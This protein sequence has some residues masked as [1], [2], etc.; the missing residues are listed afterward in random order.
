[1]AL[2]RGSVIS[3]VALAGFPAVSLAST[4]QFFSSEPSFHQF[5]DGQGK[6]LKDIE[7]FE[8]SDAPFGSKT[9]F[10]NSLQ[11]G[12][13]R[14]YFD[15]GIN[16]TNLIIQTNITQGPTPATPNPSANPN[17]LWVNGAGFIGSNSIKVGTDEFLNNLYSSID[18]IFTTDEKTAIAVDVSTYANFN[19]G[20]GG[21]LMSV[22]DTSDNVL[23]TYLI[24][25]P[26]PP[27]PAKNFFG[28]WSSTPIGRVNVWG[29]FSVP[30]P[31]A[32][33]NIEMYNAVPAPGTVGALGF[34]G[35]FGLRRRR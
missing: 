15:N 7:D 33:D 10:P 4:I 1:M 18:L 20:H 13:P 2:V 8:E 31:F 23:G 19:Q 34:L 30:Q 9:P 22:Y 21:F 25:G 28:V 17:A 24:A 11:N 27:E 14:P 12:V 3:L 26:T 16:A 6:V 35:A 29:I 32:I 5:V